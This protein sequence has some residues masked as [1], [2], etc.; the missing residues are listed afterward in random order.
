MID[1]AIFDQYSENTVECQCGATYRSHTKIAAGADG[2]LRIYSRRP[3]P[4]CRQSEG[5]PCR[6]SSDPETFVIGK[7]DM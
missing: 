1:W 4:S 2:V 6:V 7:K 3:C 5:N